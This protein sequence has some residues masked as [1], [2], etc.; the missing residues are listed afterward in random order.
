MGDK[1]GRVTAEG[2]ALTVP[3]GGAVD[4]AG[5]QAREVQARWRDGGGVTG[6]GKCGVA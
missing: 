3:G 2:W 5:G 6:R 4:G 1:W